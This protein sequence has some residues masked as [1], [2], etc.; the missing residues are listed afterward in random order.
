MVYPFLCYG[1]RKDLSWLIK[2]LLD[3]KVATKSRPKIA[4]T[5][6]K[7]VK[8]RQFGRAVRGKASQFSP[9]EDIIVGTNLSFEELVKNRVNG[10]VPKTMWKKYLSNL[11]NDEVRKEAKKNFLTIAKAV[12]SAHG[13]EAKIK[14]KAAKDLAK[15]KLSSFGIVH[16]HFSTLYDTVVK[17]FVAALKQEKET[18]NKDK[19]L[20]LTALVGKWAPTIDGAIDFSTSLG[21]NIARS[22]YSSSFPIEEWTPNEK[23][24]AYNFYRKEYLTPLRAYVHSPETFMSSKK[25]SEISY[26]RVASVSMKRNKEVFLKRDAERFGKYLEDVKA[27]VKKIASGALLPHEIIEQLISSYDFQII[28]TFQ[29]D[30]ESENDD[31]QVDKDT[32]QQTDQFEQLETDE[33]PDEKIDQQTNQLEQV[34]ELQ[35]ASYVDN[36]KKSGLID[37]ALSICDVSGSMDGEPM[38][39][40]IALSLLTAALSKPPFDNFICSFSESPSLHLVNQPTLK[41][42]VSFVR[43]MDWGMNTNMQVKLFTYSLII[44]LNPCFINCKFCTL[45]YRLFSI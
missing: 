16:K 32:D 27:G 28:S 2:F 15:V 24:K 7:A 35:W 5:P 21:K 42:K 20:P 18:L 23:K 14:K 10:K 45:F 17:L 12:Q 39:V 33:Q 34:A 37:S 26:D 40:A 3:G 30:S 9:N 11:S 36:L 29:S 43:N 13:Q 1:F 4:K 44:I 19:K 38:N 31:E 25:W 22:L 41:E 6:M 8:H